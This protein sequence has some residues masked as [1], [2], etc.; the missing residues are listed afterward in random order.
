MNILSL[1]R[2]VCW[3]LSFSWHHVGKKRL[4]TER[5]ICLQAPQQ[6]SDAR[7]GAPLLFHLC[8]ANILRGPLLSIAPRLARHTRPGGSI[9]LSGVLEGQQAA[10]VCG[11]YEAAGFEDLE[12][13]NEEG[14]SLITGRRRTE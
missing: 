10:E 1:R 12:V 9:A 7:S 2:G 3:P 5:L 4:A 8:V 6:L 14:W 11:A 13:Q